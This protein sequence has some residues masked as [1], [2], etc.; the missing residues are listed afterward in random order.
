MST[1]GKSDLDGANFGRRQL[2]YQGVSKVAE[3]SGNS[4]TGYQDGTE[5]LAAGIAFADQI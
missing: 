4:W 3:R 1:F 5:Q 2:Q